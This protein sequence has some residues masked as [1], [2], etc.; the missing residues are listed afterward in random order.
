MTV[1]VSRCVAFQSG[2]PWGANGSPEFPAGPQGSPECLPAIGI[3]EL[4]LSLRLGT[5]GADGPCAPR[6]ADH[7]YAMTVG[8]S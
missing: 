6:P 7:A 5:R 4:R 1:G 2:E 3:I 8:V